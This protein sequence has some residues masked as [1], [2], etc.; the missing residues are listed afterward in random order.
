MSAGQTSTAERISRLERLAVLALVE[1]HGVRL[2]AGFD[3]AGMREVALRDAA[4]IVQEQ[5][6]PK[7]E[8]RA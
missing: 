4:A 3:F 5:T 8:T 7:L 6:E 2:G 1:R